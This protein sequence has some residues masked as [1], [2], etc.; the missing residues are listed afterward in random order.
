MTKQKPHRL[1]RALA[2]PR[3][4]RTRRISQVQALAEEN[5]LEAMQTLVFLLDSGNDCVRE[6][7]AIA[8]LDRAYGKVPGNLKHT[9][10]RRKPK[11]LGPAK[12]NVKIMRFSE[13]QDDAG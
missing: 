4:P 3:P 1:A 7:A 12:V 13:G 5:S 9:G 6:A 10:K 2:V 8:L 11:Q